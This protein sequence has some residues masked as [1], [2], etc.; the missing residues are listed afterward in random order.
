MLSI[1]WKLVKF[2]ILHFEEEL[3]VRVGFSRRGILSTYH[4]NS[5]TAAAAELSFMR[6][7]RC[8]EDRVQHFGRCDQ[9]D[10]GIGE[11]KH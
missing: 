6:I 11:R 5:A 1:L 2:I 8:H 4:N 3:R 9:N 10:G 7:G